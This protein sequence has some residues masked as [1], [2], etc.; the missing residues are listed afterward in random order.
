MSLKPLKL[1]VLEAMS[2]DIVDVMVKHFY[3]F[4]LLLAVLLL[5]IPVLIFFLCHLRK[6]FCTKKDEKRTSN[7]TVIKCSRNVTNIEKYI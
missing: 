4:L 3:C 1:E 7:G 6:K 2:L 5:H